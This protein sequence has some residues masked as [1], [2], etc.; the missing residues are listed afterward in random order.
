MQAD[1]KTDRRMDMTK[2]R[3]AFYDYANAPKD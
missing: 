1:R 3:V 2:L